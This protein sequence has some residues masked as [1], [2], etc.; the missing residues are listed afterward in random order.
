MCIFVVL[1]STMENDF[2]MV[3]V[4]MFGLE[5]VLAKEL[6]DLGARDVLVGIRNVSFKGDKGFMYK[7][8]ISLRTAI[9]IL[10]PIRRFRVR[11]E[12][13]LYR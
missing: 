7:A 12:D 6:K 2:K 13:D 9:R 10:K 11:N 8:N 5:E 4:T 3:A 1:A